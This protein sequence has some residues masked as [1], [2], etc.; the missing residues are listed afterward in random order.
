MEL[1]SHWAN[2]VHMIRNQK[3]GNEIIFGVVRNC[4]S[5]RWAFW[6]TGESTTSVW[7][8][9][10]VPKK[11]NYSVLYAF[12]E[13]VTSLADACLHKGDFAA[14]FSPCIWESSWYRIEEGCHHLEAHKGIPEQP[15]AKIMCVIQVCCNVMPHH[16]KHRSWY[17][18][19]PAWTDSA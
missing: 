10:K 1:S 9:D 19:T 4:I 15:S 7:S 3:Q 18:K 12:N 5:H 6:Q 14:F 16:W 13:F 11:D 2:C 17:F 8:Y